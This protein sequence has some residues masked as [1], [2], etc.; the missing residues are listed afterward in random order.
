[1]HTIKAVLRM[2]VTVPLNAVQSVGFAYPQSNNVCNDL[3]CHSEQLTTIDDADCNQ[4]VRCPA[5]AGMTSSSC[6]CSCLAL[7]NGLKSIREPLQQ[8][9]VSCHPQR[10]ISYLCYSPAGARAHFCQHA[11][12]TA[13]LSKVV[14]RTRQARDTLRQ[15]HS[16]KQ[17][18]KQ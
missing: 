10:M 8:L 6:C 13:L 17:P 12:H 11:N 2:L 3:A 1:M 14:H 18:R 4:C 5:M 7:T 9:P 16:Q 15:L